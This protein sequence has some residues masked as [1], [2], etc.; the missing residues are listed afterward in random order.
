[1]VAVYSHLDIHLSLC[2]KISLLNILLMD[3]R[4][5]VHL[6]IQGFSVQISNS[7]KCENVLIKQNLLVQS[8]RRELSARQTKVVF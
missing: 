3:A 1:M 7:A 5:H 8:L 6:Y 4:P 2:A